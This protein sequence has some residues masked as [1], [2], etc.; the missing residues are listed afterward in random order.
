MS[1]KPGALEHGLSKIVRRA[2]KVVLR[3]GSTWVWI[4]PKT[5][6]VVREP[7]WATRTARNLKLFEV[8]TDKWVDLFDQVTSFRVFST[9]EAVDLPYRVSVLARSTDAE[10]IV[11][12]LA[13][14]EKAPEV[15]LKRYIEEAISIRARMLPHYDPRGL[16][17]EIALRIDEWQSEIARF[18]H[19]YCGLRIEIRFLIDVQPPEIVHELA[20][21]MCT[22]D[23]PHRQIPLT[24]HVELMPSNTAAVQPLPQ[25]PPAQRRWLEKQLGTVL[26][27]RVTLYDVW[28]EKEKVDGALIEALDEALRLSGYR[29]K[30]LKILPVKPPYPESEHLSVTV[31]W[32]GRYGRTIPFRVEATLRLTK[33]GTGR[34]DA[35]RT[36]DRGA[37]LSKEASYALDMAMQGRDFDDLNRIELVDVREAVKTHLQERGNA[38][39][40]IIEPVV[41][42]PAIPENVWLQGRRVTKMTKGYKLKESID[43][44]LVEL[45]VEIA[46]DSLRP[47]IDK[48]RHQDSFN[49]S[50]RNNNDLI[51]L[52]VLEEAADELEKYISG[53]NPD[54]Y[55]SEWDNQL[56]E[57]MDQDE[58]A[59]RER[60]SPPIHKPLRDQCVAAIEDRLRKRLKPTMVSVTLNR[61]LSPLLSLAQVAVSLGTVKATV[62]VNPK[63]IQTELDSIP[64]DLR[65]HVVGLNPRYYSTVALRGNPNLE[66]KSVEETI[67]DAAIQHLS[68]RPIDYIQRLE[69]GLNSTDNS[70]P[71]EQLALAICG[72]LAYLHG[73]NTVLSSALPRPSIALK[74]ILGVRADEMRAQYNRVERD[75]FTSERELITYQNDYDALEEQ[76]KVLQGRL[77]NLLANGQSGSPAYLNDEAELARLQKKR[78]Q[79]L[80]DAEASSRRLSSGGVAG[81]I[82]DTSGSGQE[83]RDGN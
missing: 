11:R 24:I 22:L 64:V 32:K 50:N 79:L 66:R 20:L 53:I 58:A 73:I 17:A 41:I 47:I 57:A 59:P 83:G 2:Q 34:F 33:A 63:E 18:M 74:T 44:A 8:V 28:F 5:G 81:S 6:E 80:G 46:F 77:R 1:D 45:V 48:I 12:S 7:G 52:L 27:A 35:E 68:G 4:D 82:S 71:F 62:I 54:N 31:D 37:W 76:I 13:D 36:S 10:K 19:D 25:D 26:P 30:G 55:Y 70:T 9:T 3:A 38:I 15:V 49:S 72:R 60:A 61:D 56:A 40:Q 43:Q 69:E 14:R 78:S 42:D 75:R 51:E 29:V 65:V 23:A 16:K 67:Q 39:G 21:V